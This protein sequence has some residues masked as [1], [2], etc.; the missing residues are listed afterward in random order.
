MRCPKLYITPAS[1]SRWGII[2]DL[3]K[4]GVRISYL[5]WEHCDREERVAFWWVVSRMVPIMSMISDGK[6]GPK[7]KLDDD[8]ALVY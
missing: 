1:E 5:L 2:T 4:R 8:I 3:Y 6:M 7:V